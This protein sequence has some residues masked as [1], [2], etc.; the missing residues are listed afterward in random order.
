M[1]KGD[2]IFAADQ[3]ALTPPCVKAIVVEHVAAMMIKLPLDDFLND[4]VEGTNTKNRDLQIVYTG[5]F[6]T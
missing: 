3:G 6:V 5:E 2:R 1:I 4:E